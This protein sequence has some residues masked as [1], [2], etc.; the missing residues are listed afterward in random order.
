MLVESPVLYR[1]D[2]LREELAELVLAD[3]PAVL[4]RLEL[5]YAVSRHVIR[6]GVLDQLRIPAV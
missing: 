3:R 2:R 6:G 4:S 5:A 1:D